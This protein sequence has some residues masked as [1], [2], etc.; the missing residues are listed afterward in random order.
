ERA[1]GGEP[2]DSPMGVSRDP[3]VH[4]AGREPRPLEAPAPP[5][6]AQARWAAVGSALLVASAVALITVFL[7]QHC[8]EL[9]SLPASI[10]NLSTAAARWGLVALPGASWTAAGALAAG[11]VAAAWF[12]AGDVLLALMR[13]MEPGA[14]QNSTRRLADGATPGSVALGV[15]RRCALGAGP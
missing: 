6:A 1:A 15:A 5:R 13:R 3:A 9:T 11:L 14:A 2:S 12:G 4:R 7:A 8:A 10:R